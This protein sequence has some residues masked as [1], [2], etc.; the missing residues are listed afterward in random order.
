MTELPVDN[1]NTEEVMNFYYLAIPGDYSDYDIW[2]NN[3]K[4]Y[5]LMIYFEAKI[6][7]RYGK[8]EYCKSLQ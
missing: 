5:C 4:L 8:E 3:K 7:R 1:V 6:K 2:R